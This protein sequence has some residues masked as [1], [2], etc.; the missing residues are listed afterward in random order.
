MADSMARQ[1]N[2]PIPNPARR[3]SRAPV[4]TGVVFAGGL[5]AAAVGAAVL[6][7][8]GQPQSVETPT[9]APTGL[10]SEPPKTIAPATEAPKTPEPPLTN[11]QKIELAKK[12]QK[13]SLAKGEFR[14]PVSQQMLDI[15]G[16]MEQGSLL[17]SGE[18]DLFVV[19]PPNI[20]FVFPS[21][22][23]GKV[24]GVDKAGPAINV[25]S[26]QVDGGKNVVFISIANP[27][28][29]VGDMV[30]MGSALFRLKYDPDSAQQKTFEERGAEVKPKGTVILIGV[31][32][33]G[34][35]NGKGF[36]ESSLDKTTLRDSDGKPISIPT[37][38]G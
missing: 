7:G 26:I 14:L 19:V 8:R 25:V 11:E 32:D 38:K 34:M 1:E 28:I 27:T 23:D 21:L 30:S 6:G 17:P 18:R 37:L 36:Q 3:N 2:Q 10:V 29:K 22:I 13:E 12:A 9:P 4:I 20:E 35:G 33:T 5:A 31:Q 24:I 16:R 15:G